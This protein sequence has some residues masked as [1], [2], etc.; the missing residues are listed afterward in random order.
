LFPLSIRSK[1]VSATTAA[2]WTFN[3]ALSWFVPSAFVNIKW[4]TFIVF[5]CFL[6]AMTFHF[7]FCFPETAGKTLEEIE[8]I[9]TAKTPA[10]K[11]KVGR[12]SALQL[13]HTGTKTE[14][15]AETKQ[16]VER[17]VHLEQTDV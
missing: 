4:K 1:A 15:T 2:N 16:A 14:D 13:E 9:F 3:F 11:T 10:W 8:D 7:F 17:A 5:G 12:K 6:V